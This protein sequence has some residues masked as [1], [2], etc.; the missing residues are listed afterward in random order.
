MGD[1][2]PVHAHTP[3]LMTWR[4]LTTFLVLSRVDFRADQVRLG[5]SLPFALLTRG[6]ST[7]HSSFAD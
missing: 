3:V 1:R 2:D 7:K 5:V 6:S 4:L